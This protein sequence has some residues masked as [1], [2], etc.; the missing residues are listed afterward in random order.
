ME[1]KYYSGQVGETPMVI[2]KELR[3][4]CGHPTF[5][6]CFVKS[7]SLF[8]HV[9]VNKHH[10]SADEIPNTSSR[11]RSFGI[12]SKLNIFMKPD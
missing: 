5:S 9:T 1:R 12:L 3:V 6:F 2:S 10:I 11:N 7:Y 8:G 4:V